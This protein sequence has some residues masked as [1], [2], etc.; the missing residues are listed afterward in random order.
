MAILFVSEGVKK[1]KLKFKDIS[2][3]IKQIILNNNLIAG[4]ITYIFCNDEYLLD[5]NKRFLTHD[6]FTDIITFDYC[7]GNM[8]SGDMYISVDRV[9]ENCEVFN[10]SYENEI[11]RVVVHGL[12]HLLGYKDS[13]DTERELIREMENKCILIFQNIENGCFK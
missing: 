2:F 7:A 9:K 10:D 1:P 8:I 13:S 12:L 11:L 3:W 5:I 4:N 6:Y